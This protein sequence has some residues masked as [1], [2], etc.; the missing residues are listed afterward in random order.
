M[1]LIVSNIV[2]NCIYM[3]SK[4]AWGPLRR[5]RPDCDRAT[6]CAQCLA[7]RL[8]RRDRCRR[9]HP[10]RAVSFYWRWTNRPANTILHLKAGRWP[11]THLP[12]L[13]AGKL[14]RMLAACSS[15]RA[16]PSMLHVPM[17]G[18]C[19]TCCMFECGATAPH[20]AGFNAGPRPHSL[21]EELLPSMLYR[22]SSEMACQFPTCCQFECEVIARQ[23][24]L[25][26]HMFAFRTGGT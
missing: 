9:N 13:N 1:S 4:G 16:L 24:P 19:P 17:Q 8:P 14:P 26:L 3:Y 7:G 5:P 12:L 23:S 11:A 2:Y 6:F 10:I 15:S 21:N 20:S 22:F 25:M 18:H